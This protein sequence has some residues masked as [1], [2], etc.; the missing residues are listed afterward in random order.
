[1]PPIPDNPPTVNDVARQAGANPITL[2]SDGNPNKE[3]AEGEASPTGVTDLYPSWTDSK[4][5][6]S[7]YAKGADVDALLDVADTLD[8]LADTGDLNE[9]YQPPEIEHIPSIPE[10]KTGLGDHENSA[11]VCTLPRVDSNMESIV[12]SLPSL[13]A[14]SMDNLNLHKSSSMTSQQL[15]TF[16]S[17]LLDPH[18]QVFDTPLEEQDFVSAIL[19]QSATE[20]HDNLASL[21]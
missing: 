10:M 18:L 21:S 8:W 3:A 6:P 17:G 4:D 14:Q 9:T 7:W 12:P 11:S 5:A 1:M 19:E 15:K 16:P 20:S 2:P 13:F